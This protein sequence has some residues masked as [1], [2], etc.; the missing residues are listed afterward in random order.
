MFFSID[1]II[2]QGH[3]HGLVQRY[4]SR[5]PVYISYHVHTW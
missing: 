4:K 2:L 1:K 3:F 5:A